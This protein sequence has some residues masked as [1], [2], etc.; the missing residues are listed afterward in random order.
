MTPHTPEPAAPATPA[1]GT[2]APRTVT[3]DGI[4]LSRGSRVLLRPRARGDVLDLALTG[5]PA[6]VEDVEEDTEGRIHVVVTLEADEGRHFTTGLGHRFFFAPDEVEPAGPPRKHTARLLVAG[7]GNV[8]LAD[9][10]FGPEVIAALGT[11][12]GG[13]PAG[14]QAADFGIRGLDLAYRLLDGYDTA[15]FVDA[16]PRGA[17]PGTLHLIE[18]DTADGAGLGT[19]APQGHGMD[20]VRVL[21][22]AARLAEDAGTPLPRVVVLG[23]EP[24]VRLRG[25]EPDVTVGLSAPV[26]AAVDEAVAL[27]HRVAAALLADPRAALDSL[28]AGG[29]SGPCPRPA[30]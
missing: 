4:P 8:F 24:L 12:P 7:I 17:A 26:R 23:C 13:L 27:L 5:R 20:P 3:V 16:A 19:A 15:V 11:G 1:A 2:H 14:V 25:D 29:R 9:D 18:P 6:E 28:L 10:A 22:L 21:A 30:P